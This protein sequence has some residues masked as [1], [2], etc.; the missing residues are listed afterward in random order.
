MIT[1]KQFYSR[2]GKANRAILRSAMHAGNLD[3]R[4]QLIR[5]GREVVSPFTMKVPLSRE[6][7]YIERLFSMTNEVIQTS[8]ARRNVEIYLSR[9]P[10]AA[11]EV[12]RSAYLRFHL[13]S[14]FNELYIL[15][16][17]MDKFAVGLCREFRS[18]RNAAEISSNIKHI[19][20]EIKRLFGPS[21]SIRGK[22]VHQERYDDSEFH[23]LRLWE[24]LADI[25]PDEYRRHAQRC[26][27]IVRKENLVFVKKVNEG[28]GEKLDRFFSYFE[29]L[30]FEESGAIRYP[31]N[32]RHV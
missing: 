5:A 15:Q 16:L 6:E 3:F 28:V 30:I 31:S 14:F 8:V 22:H 11:Q 13:A 7:Q 21:G 29:D 23:Q 12:S 32:I 19:R 2:I 26:A 17:R 10:F 25:R 9:F 18:E 20:S 1:H 24:M 4:P 27:S